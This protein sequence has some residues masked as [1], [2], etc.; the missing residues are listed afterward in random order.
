MH[1]FTINF[2]CL[3]KK[4]Y[5]KINVYTNQYLGIYAQGIYDECVKIS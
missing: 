4:N 1:F 2:S 3:V 5:S